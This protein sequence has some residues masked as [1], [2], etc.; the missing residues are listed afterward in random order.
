VWAPLP[1]PRRRSPWWRSPVTR[2]GN[3]PRTFE[4]PNLLVCETCLDTGTRIAGHA[5]TKITEEY[6]IVQMRRQEELTR[7]IQ[8]KRL[9]AAKRSQKGPQVVKKAD[10]E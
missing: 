6:T 9:K 7:R 8:D 2:G 5:N 4:G 10:A 3:R 1:W